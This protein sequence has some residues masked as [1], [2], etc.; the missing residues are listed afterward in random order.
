MYRFDHTEIVGALF[1]LAKEGKESECIKL[2]S[3]HPELLYEEL[4]R[5]DT[6]IIHLASYYNLSHVVDYLVEHD[7]NIHELNFNV[8][9]AIFYAKHENMIKKL[10]SLGISINNGNAT[11]YS[12]LMIACVKNDINKVKWLI[13]TGVDVNI[14][15]PFNWDILDYIKG[16]RLNLKISFLM[17]Y[18]NNF[19]KENQKKLKKLRLKHLVEQGAV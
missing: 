15:G 16:N 11:G 10:H 5:I 9:N 3:Q 1:E 6:K 19:N 14:V 4:N 18:Y 2:L 8:E 17:N 13:E 7:V 12:A